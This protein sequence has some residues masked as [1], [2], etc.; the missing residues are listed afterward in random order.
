MLWKTLAVSLPFALADENC[1]NWLNGSEKAS[2]TGQ[3]NSLSLTW[4]EKGG[5]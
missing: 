2:H 4:E 1:A 5:K 3:H